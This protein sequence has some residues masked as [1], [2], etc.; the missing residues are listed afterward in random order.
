MGDVQAVVHIV[1]AV[2]N[3]G[4]VVQIG[5]GQAA[6]AF[7]GVEAGEHAVNIGLGQAG[8]GEDLV[9][10]S[11][12]VLVVDVQS[13]VDDGN[14]HALTGV[15]LGPGVLTANHLAVGNGPG[16]DNVGR[17]GV[18]GGAGLVHGLHDHLVHA[19]H[20][21]NVGQ[22]AI[23]H[24]GGHAVDQP[25]V[26]VGHGE[27]VPIQGGLLDVG[28]DLVLVG[29]DLLHLGCGVVGVH[30]GAVGGDHGVAVHD[31]DDPHVLVG[32]DGV[33]QVVLGHGVVPGQGQVV[34]GAVQLL[35]F[36]TVGL[37]GGSLAGVSAGG[38]G[39]GG[40]AHGDGKS[41]APG[42]NQGQQTL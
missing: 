38:K 9:G 7:I 27:V 1:E 39:E 2:G 21:L 10:E 35:H 20:R 29:L 25:A 40:S 23:G 36:H 37:G 31:N 24:G 22:L 15:A 42:E 30:S 17:S 16:I 41:Q 12:E 34:V 6:V 18:V 4:V 33:G 19:V 26:L 14:L 8:V 3:L 13:G 32:G 5:A 11:G 28:N